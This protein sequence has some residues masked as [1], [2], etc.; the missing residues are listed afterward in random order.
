MNNLEI[1]QSVIDQ[2]SR[3]LGET[4]ANTADEARV[5]CLIVALAINLVA[6]ALTGDVD[7]AKR[8]IFAQSKID[9]RQTSLN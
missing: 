8:V 7:A 9:V 3:M 4:K 2:A 5:Q 6:D 1:L